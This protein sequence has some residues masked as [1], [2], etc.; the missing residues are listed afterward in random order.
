MCCIF[1]R[2]EYDDEIR[3]LLLKSY[4]GRE[5]TKLEHKHAMGQSI[6]CAFYW[7]SWGLF[8]GSVGED[9]GFFFLPAYRYLIKNIDNVI[10]SYKK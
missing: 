1:T 6:L 8:K 10:E 4:Y 9:D 3:E 2:Y 7:F 5:L